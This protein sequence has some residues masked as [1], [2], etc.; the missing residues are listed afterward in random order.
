MPISKTAQKLPGYLWS[1]L[2]GAGTAA[3]N[4]SKSNWLKA[5]AVPLKGIGTVAGKGLTTAIKAP[6]WAGKMM[7]NHP[8]I[9]VPLVGGTYLAGKNF[10][11]KQDR[12]SDMIDPNNNSVR[13]EGMM[14]GV[15]KQADWKNNIELIGKALSAG[16]TVYGAARAATNYVKDMGVSTTQ[17]QVITKLLNTDPILKNADRES[18]LS[19][20]KTICNMAPKVSQDENVVKDLLHNFVK[21]GRIDLQSLK[22]L[23]DT[24]KAYSDTAKNTNMLYALGK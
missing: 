22:L 23:T 8:G 6:V 17:Q 3:T 21:F 2:I 1:K 24:E 12:Y 13:Y 19:Y 15:T 9:A 14:S 18:V 4:V 11:D 5:L 16:A 10:I 20:Y 7:Y